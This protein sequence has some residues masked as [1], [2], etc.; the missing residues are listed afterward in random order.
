MQ[1][2]NT[3]IFFLTEEQLDY[4]EKVQK[5]VAKK[6]V[7]NLSEEFVDQL[8]ERFHNRYTD[9]NK[10]CVSTEA[11]NYDDVKDGRNLLEGKNENALF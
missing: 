2:N 6:S 7:S 10:F 4:T 9:A 1:Y 8:K 11:I 5:E 3:N